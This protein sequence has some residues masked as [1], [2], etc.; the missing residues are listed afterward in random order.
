M[1]SWIEESK[2]KVISKRKKPIR[3]RKTDTF[4]QE[5]LE[6]A[7]P[8]PTIDEESSDESATTKTD[9]GC[10]SEESIQEKS[11]TIPNVESTDED[12]EKTIYL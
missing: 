8:E 7:K 3:K 4:I 9:I 1:E 11:Y 12:V 10:K 5:I 6:R 2:A